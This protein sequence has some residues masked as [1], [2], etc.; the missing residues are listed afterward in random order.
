MKKTKNAVGTV[1]VILAVLLA[2]LLVGVRLAGLQVYTVLSGSMEPAY[3]VG[4]V[5]YVKKVPAEDI[6]I[7]D[8]ITFVLDESLV[9]ATHRVIEIE[10]DE[11]GM[12]RFRTKGDANETPDGSPV[13]AQN[14]LGRPVFTVPYLG[15]FVSFIQHPPGSYIALAAGAVLLLLLFLPDRTA[16]QDQEKEAQ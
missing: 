10:T 13:L 16:K 5:I 6:K 4:S 12:I 3:H 7:G 2:V 14:L 15:Y 11:D 9:V 1:I 8:P